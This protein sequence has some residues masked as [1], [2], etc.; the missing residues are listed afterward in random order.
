MEGL[1]YEATLI[2]NVALYGVLAFIAAVVVGHWKWA[3]AIWRRQWPQV[4]LLAFSLLIS[5]AFAE[6]AIRLLR[7][8]LAQRP[9]ERLAS[10]TLHHVNAPNRSSLGMGNQRVVTNGDGFRSAYD[11]EAFLEFPQRIVLLGDSYTF[12]LGV[13]ADETVGS[14]LES[15]LRQH[16][17]DP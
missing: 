16:L 2:L 7:P 3:A 11:R 1:T 13:A 8:E 10:A 5:A 14:V 9:F 12:G 6:V 17:G 4:A 15:R